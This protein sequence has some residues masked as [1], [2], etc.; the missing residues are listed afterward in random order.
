MGKSALFE[1]TMKRT[2]AVP[3]EN[4]R[5]KTVYDV[6]AD[7]MTTTVTTAASVATASVLTEDRLK[8]I[9]QKIERATTLP[10]KYDWSVEY[11]DAKFT[12]KADA[13]AADEERREFYR[14]KEAGSY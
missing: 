6:E 10:I 11:G 9:M 2:I 5:T 12:S 8:E 14:Q 4:L 7:A 13:E 1:E 3:L